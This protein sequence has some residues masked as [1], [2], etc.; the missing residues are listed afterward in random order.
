MAG[1]EVFAPALAGR[2]PVVERRA[3][4][5]PELLAQQSQVARLSAGW[6]VPDAALRAHPLEPLSEPRQV[7]LAAPRERRDE[8][9]PQ[10][11]V[12]EL[13]EMFPAWLAERGA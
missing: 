3:Q 4:F 1:R 11:S 6:A 8:L 12:V 10:A 9:V 5:L 13:R 7:A 2:Q